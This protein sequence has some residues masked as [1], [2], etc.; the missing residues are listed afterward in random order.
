[1][2]KKCLTGN[3]KLFPERTQK[4]ACKRKKKAQAHSC[5]RE[6]EAAR[7]DRTGQDRGDEMFGK[8]S[9]IL[10]LYKVFFTVISLRNPTWTNQKRNGA[11]TVR[12]N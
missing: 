3:L 12:F 5:Y 11:H 4:E 8:M 7:Q 1:M 6:R 10:T 2:Q 9:G